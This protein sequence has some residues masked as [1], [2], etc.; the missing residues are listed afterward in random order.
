MSIDTE[1]K[2][3]SRIEYTQ[4]F[5]NYVGFMDNLDIE[6]LDRYKSALSEST[7]KLIVESF[8]MSDEEREEK[9]LSKYQCAME[10]RAIVAD[11]ESETP[12]SQYMW[13][14]VHEDNAR[15]ISALDEAADQ[16]LFCSV[17]LQ[18]SAEVRNELVKSLSED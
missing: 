5:R 4:D 12:H 10:K 13:A 9:A 7:I 11:L 14:P 16:D 8:E 15:M 2:E 6:E 1:P 18:L 3:K 17:A